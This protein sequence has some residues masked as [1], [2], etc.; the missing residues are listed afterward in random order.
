MGFFSLLPAFRAF[1]RNAGGTY[2]AIVGRGPR[3]VR[4]TSSTWRRDVF[5]SLLPTAAEDERSLLVLSAEE[6][7]SFAFP[8]PRSSLLDSLRPCSWRRPGGMYNCFEV[9]C[10]VIGESREESPA[11]D[12]SCAKA[13]P[14]WSLDVP[15][16]AAKEVEALTASMASEPL[17]VSMVSFAFLDFLSGFT[18]SFSPCFVRDGL[19]A[20][21]VSSTGTLVNLSAAAPA[22]PAAV[23]E[24]AGFETAGFEIAAFAIAA[25]AAAAASAPIALCSWFRVSS[26]FRFLRDEV[27]AVVV[28]GA[29]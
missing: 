17:L 23:V 3:E 5:R 20:V 26:H 9:D 13:G 4:G 24:I 11:D 19:D 14:T 21:A 6:P 25:L 12:L 8:V 1:A 10:F 27:D 15:P 29:R 18:M 2:G 22:A 16:V 7:L 28:L